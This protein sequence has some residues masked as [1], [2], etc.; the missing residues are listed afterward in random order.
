MIGKLKF[1]IRGKI[2]FQDR[3]VSRTVFKAI[4]PDIVRNEV[5]DVL[6]KLDLTDEIVYF[7]IQSSSYAKFRGA[8]TSFLRLIRTTVELIEE[9]RI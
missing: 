7:E 9:V 2:K 1:T 3:Y 8:L 5:R 4:Y 6:V